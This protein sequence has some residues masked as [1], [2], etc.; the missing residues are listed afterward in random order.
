MRCRSAEV[1]AGG[2]NKAI[3]PGLRIHRG[4]CVSSASYTC[5]SSTL[6][7]S[8][9]QVPFLDTEAQP[10][11]PGALHSLQQYGAQSVLCMCLNNNT[12]NSMSANPLSGKVHHCLHKEGA[13]THTH[14]AQVRKAP[15]S[16][17][18]ASASA[19]FRMALN[20]MGALN[21]SRA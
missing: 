12:Y 16:H 1:M 21:C 11:R 19:C 17:L 14:T 9:Q 3:S 7:L 15:K 20:R 8:L 2:T 13:H 5:H 18:P 10:L 4:Y 6:K